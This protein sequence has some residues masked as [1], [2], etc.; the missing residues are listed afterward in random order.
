RYDIGN[1]E[2]LSDNFCFHA[3]RCSSIGEILEYLA[4]QIEK[5]LDKISEDKRLKDT[6]PIRMAKQYIQEHYSRQITLEEVSS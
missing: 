3:G 4:I 5:S 6:K 2:E 1:P